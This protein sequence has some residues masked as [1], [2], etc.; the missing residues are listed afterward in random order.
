MALHVQNN[1]ET[2]MFYG[3][4]SLS[5]APPFLNVTSLMPLSPRQIFI[6]SNIISLLKIVYS[7]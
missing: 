7:V 5:H 6:L 1:A 3:Q 4:Q 2:Y